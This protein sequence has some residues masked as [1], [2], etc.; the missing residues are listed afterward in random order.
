MDIREQIGAGVRGGLLAALPI[1]LAVFDRSARLVGFSPAYAALSGLE[2][3]YLASR[4]SW[5]DLIARLHADRRLPEVANLPVWRDEE[6]HRLASLVRTVEERQY[7]P[8]GTVLKR[9]ASPLPSGGFIL[10]YEDLTPRL[11]AE[12]AANEAAQIQR[13]TLDHLDDALAVFGADGRLKFANRAFKQLWSWDGDRIG[14][15]LTV[16]NS[17]WTVAQ[18]L[19]RIPGTAHVERHGTVLAAYHLPLPDGAVLL[20]YA[21]VTPAKRL[22]EALR[23]QAETATA[24]DRMKS[25]FVAILAHE[26]RVPLTTI[27]GFAEMLAGGYAGPLAGRQADYADNIVTTAHQLARLIDDVLDLACIDAGMI[28]LD[29]TSLDLHTALAGLVTNLAEQVR[30]KRLTLAFDCSPSIGRIDG[31]ERRLRQAVL[32]LLNNAIAYTPAGGTVTLSAKRRRD[33]IEIVVDD[34]GMGIVRNELAH[35]TKPFVRGS[36][37]DVSGPGA[38]LGLTLVRRFV[39][40]HGGDLQLISQ[41]NRGTTATIRL[42]VST[43]FSVEKSD[44][45][46]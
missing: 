36:G 21:D 6:R 16:S 44:A 13:Q 8:D 28:Q 27:A 11:I 20:H 46:G 37:A 41:R 33:A 30:A 35:V 3:I 7:L 4:P 42:P 23:A 22:E 15:F 25:E 2:T 43:S 17:A 18:L 40:L 14:D 12:R 26:A 19:S 31:D 10:A 29:A 24:A 34:T 39:A 32:H 5:S 45:S 38:G 9:T 1:P